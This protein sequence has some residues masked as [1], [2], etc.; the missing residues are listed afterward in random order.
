M[1]SA[2][3]SL[4]VDNENSAPVEESFFDKIGPGGIYFRYSEITIAVLGLIFLGLLTMILLPY[5]TGGQFQNPVSHLFGNLPIKNKQSKGLPS[6]VQ[7]IVYPLASGKQTWQFS[8]GGGVTGPNLQTA[9]VDPLDPAKGATQTITATA[10]N[11]TPIIK[12]TVTLTTPISF[13]L[14]FPNILRVSVIR[15]S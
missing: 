12:I 11:G 8:R 14:I 4:P 10:Q 15:S 5:L 9:A 1:I 6:G 2:K 7:K 13:K 3:G